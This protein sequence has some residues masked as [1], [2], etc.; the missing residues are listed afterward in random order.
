MAKDGSVTYPVVER[1]C[2]ELL[3]RGQ[4]PSR[5]AV[6]AL[7]ETDEYLGRKGSNAVVQQYLNEFW[8]VVAK[9]QI[10]P[11]RKVEGMPDEYVGV[12]DRAL[13]ELV[14]I[15][16]EMAAKEVA[17][18]REAL[19]SHEAKMDAAVQ[20]ARDAAAAA[21][22]LRLRAE[23]ERNAVEQRLRDL[24]AELGEAKRSIQSGQER[25]SRLSA[26]MRERDVQIRHLDAALAAA[27]SAAADAAS[28]HEAE[29]NRLLTQV[30]EARQRS[31]KEAEASKALNAKNLE[32]AQDLATTR[33]HLASATEATQRAQ[34]GLTAAN[35][36]LAES[37]QKLEQRDGQIA[38]LERKV[39]SQE[40]RIEAEE[41]QRRE[42][43][44]R[45]EQ[46]LEELGHLR[47]RIE[48]LEKLPK[49]AAAAK[50][51]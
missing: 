43:E 6:Q 21:D 14:N 15:S 37:K 8:D 46:H 5:P 38:A 40:L 2:N 20:T 22:Q 41:R 1:A 44:T 29:R 3:A 23:G 27:K 17:A 26:D 45:L 24:T 51:A 30:D 9:N 34:D 49:D 28:Q 36:K 32:L 35:Q 50:E 48:E 13:F 18:E 19:K 39:L 4:K 33:A 11:P 10:A 7:L 25:E 16:R 31:I 42:A 47:G 12:L